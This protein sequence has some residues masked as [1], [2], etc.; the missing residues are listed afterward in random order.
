MVLYSFLGLS[1]KKMA[2][3][4]IRGGGKKPRQT[5]TELSIENVFGLRQVTQFIVGLW[6]HTD[7]HYK[8]W[9]SVSHPQCLAQRPSPSTSMY[10]KSS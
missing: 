1:N 2:V 6:V 8:L 4:Y 3:R 5:P 9:T 10:G 7:I